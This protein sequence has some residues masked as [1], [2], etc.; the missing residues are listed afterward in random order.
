MEMPTYD[1][2]IEKWKEDLIITRAKMLGFRAHELPDALQEVVLELLNFNYDPNHANGATEKTVL[3]T[4]IDNHLRKMKRSATRYRAHLERLGEG[5]TGLSRD[6][7]DPRA[8]DI[9]SAVAE[10]TKR[11][12]A[13]CRGLADGLSKTQIARELGC[14]WHTVDRIIRRLR[15]Q[16]KEL[17]LGGW[18]YE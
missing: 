5:A 1:G 4:V 17:G 18:L 9:A 8:I 6:T 3:T 7:V 2:V 13:V 12:Q 11:E 14:G 10:L 15:T 16:F